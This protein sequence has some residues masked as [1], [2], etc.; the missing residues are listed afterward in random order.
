MEAVATLAPLMREIVSTRTNSTTT[1]PTTTL[2]DITS[3]TTVVTTS[4]SNS[5]SNPMG[6]YTFYCIIQTG[7]ITKEK[8]LVSFLTRPNLTK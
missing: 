4:T 2:S 8:F 1:A 7:L 3:A 6:K 5:S